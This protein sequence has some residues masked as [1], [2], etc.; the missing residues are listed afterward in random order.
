MTVPVEVTFRDIEHS[1]AVETRIR[2]KA[3]KLGHFHDRIVSCHVVVESPQR[4]Q[5]Q[6][7]LMAVRID[8]NVPGKEIVVNKIENE[9]VYVAIRDAFNAATRQLEDFSRRQ[10]GDVKNHSR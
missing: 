9:D 2:E 4:Q 7:K 10:R 3:A 1:D 5:H 8:L 6:G